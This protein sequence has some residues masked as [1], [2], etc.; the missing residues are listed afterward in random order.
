MKVV[1]I[2]GA[3]GVGKSELAFLLASLL[4]GELISCDS[5]Q[6]FKHLQIGANKTPLTAP[7]RE[8]LLDVVELDETFT[9]ADYYE[10]VLRCIAEVHGRGRLPIVVGG[11]G[12]YLDWLL[13]GRPSAPE[14]DPSALTAIESQLNGLTWPAAL[15]QLAAVDPLTAARLLPNDWYRLKRAL[16]VHHATGQALSSF[17]T[18]RPGP[19]LDFR[20]F[21][22]QAAQREQ[23]CRVIDER[24]EE[25]I[26]RGLFEEVARLCELERGLRKETQ[27]GRSI[28]YFQV[29][30]L[31]ERLRGGLDGKGRDGDGRDGKGNGLDRDGNGDNHSTCTTTS[32]TT[33]ITLI[34][35]EFFKFLNDFK[36][37]T[38][39]YSRKQEHW[40]TTRP[41]FK[42]LTRPQPLSPLSRDCE[43]VR[44][45]VDAVRAGSREEYEQLM[46]GVDEEA[47]ALRRG[48]E[49]QRYTQRLMKAYQSTGSRF[50]GGRLESIIQRL[51]KCL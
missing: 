21:Y 33:S 2:G 30:E 39:Q 25:M 44:L 51:M 24:C 16:A 36:S 37:A 8:H 48:K 42:F 5:V 34:T 18:R 11:S 38:R 47:R 13:R 31:F 19:S 3:T 23:I 26:E 49:R 22:L 15:D 12:F 1:V 50:V 28:G 35:R 10:A 9:A 46:R 20:C 17:S 41:I 6:V 29:L 40:F 45:V 14:T 27:A 7:V 4:D 32:T 43:M